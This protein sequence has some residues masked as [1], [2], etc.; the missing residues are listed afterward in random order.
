MW[1]KCKDNLYYRLMIAHEEFKEKKYEYELSW[2]NAESNYQHQLVPKAIR[3]IVK[4]N[5]RMQRFNRQK[6]FLLS[7]NNSNEY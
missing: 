5:E 2:I 3:V 1:P 6:H 7:L 4:N